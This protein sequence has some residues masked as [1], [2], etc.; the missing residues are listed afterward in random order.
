MQLEDDLGGKWFLVCQREPE[1]EKVFWAL[2]VKLYSCIVLYYW[3][4]GF[5]Q[6][7]LD[8]FERPKNIL[9]NMKAPK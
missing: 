6:G 4:G 9:W 2:A 7:E 3:L 8:T 1:Q 5:G